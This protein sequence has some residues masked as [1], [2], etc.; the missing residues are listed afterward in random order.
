MDKQQEVDIIAKRV[1]KELND[2]DY[3]NLGIGIPTAVANHVPEGIEITIHSENGVI[4]V[5]SAPKAG[6]EDDNLV[7]AGA[8]HITVNKGASYFDSATSFAIIRGAHLDMTVL[9]ALQ[10]D[11]EGSIANW[12]I[13]GKYIPGIGGAMDLLNSTKKI[14]ASLKHMDKKGNSK[15]LKKCTLPLTAY[16]KVN[17]IVTEMACMEVTDKGLVLKEIASWTNVED[18]IKATEA[19]LIIPDNIATF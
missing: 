17:L 15:I 3:V 11:Q 9:G 7:N 10:V 12:I 13:P 8:G 16:K 2:G 5:G 6:E 18:V 14:V 19:D 1:A 4:G